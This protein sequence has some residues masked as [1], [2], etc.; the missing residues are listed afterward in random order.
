MVPEGFSLLLSN[1]QILDRL[2][3]IAADLRADLAGR[4]V[5]FVGVLDGALFVL[6]DLIRIAQLDAKVDF[7]RVS[8]YR[9]GTTSGELR[10]LSGMT[11]DVSG[12]DIVLVDDIL[13]T[14]K[15]L[16]FCQE[17]LLRMGATSVRC[18]VLLTKERQQDYV[19]E[20]PI[21]GF[22]IP[23]RFVIGYGLDFEGRFRHLPDIYEKEEA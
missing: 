16:A 21:I 13:D 18:V 3:E 5:T 10:L 6:T 23:D 22:E 12:R 4:P 14:G 20:N 17:H 8:S 7:L 19:I 15:T 11:W 2:R 1:A 9:G